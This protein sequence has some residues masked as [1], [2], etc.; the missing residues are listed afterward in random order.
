MA[1]QGKQVWLVGEPVI[2][3]VQQG[4]DLYIIIPQLAIRQ[5]LLLDPLG[6]IITPMRMMTMIGIM[7]NKELPMY[8]QMASSIYILVV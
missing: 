8:R 1:M 4:K 5:D 2:K 3:E 7:S 6:I